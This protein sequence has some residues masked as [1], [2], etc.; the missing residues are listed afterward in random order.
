MMLI[1]LSIKAGVAQMQNTVPTPE[2][3]P[4]Q[5]PQFRRLVVFTSLTP[6]PKT[7]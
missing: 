7:A 3:R 5:R 2:P 1:V 6:Q 4:E